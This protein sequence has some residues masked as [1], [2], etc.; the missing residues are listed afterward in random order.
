MTTTRNC[1]ELIIARE[2]T[3]HEAK[4][5]PASTYG[6]ARGP[7]H[8]LIGLVVE[9]LLPE[10]FSEA[11]ILPVSPGSASGIDARR[12]SRRWSWARA[13]SGKPH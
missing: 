2:K 7:E 10:G 9:T 11:F 12:L 13:V 8:A 3:Y 1:R 4:K 6:D 5:A